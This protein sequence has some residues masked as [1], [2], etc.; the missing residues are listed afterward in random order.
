[1]CSEKITWLFPTEN[2]IRQLKPNHIF[3][4]GNLSD[5]NEWLVNLYDGYGRLVVKGTC[6]MQTPI[7]IENVTITALFDGQGIFAGYST[8]I[9]IPSMNLLKVNYYDNYNYLQLVDDE[10][11]HNCHLCLKPNMTKILPILSLL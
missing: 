4:D 6:V 7:S 5:R 11:R 2:D 1:M 3:Q 8:N 10:N 9:S